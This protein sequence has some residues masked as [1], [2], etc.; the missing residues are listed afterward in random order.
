[1]VNNGID[2]RWRYVVLY[3]EITEQNPGFIQAPNN[4]RLFLSCICDR[5][6]KHIHW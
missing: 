3:G 1:M 6:H 5:H 4:M 2:G